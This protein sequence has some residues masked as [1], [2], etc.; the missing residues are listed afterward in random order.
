MPTQ[1]LALAC[2][3]A[4]PAGALTRFTK[5]LLGSWTLGCKVAQPM[6]CVPGYFEVINPHTVGSLTIPRA[7]VV[8]TL[9]NTY[10]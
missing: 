3:L 4:V 8:K 6:S 10:G 7:V 9:C 2:A 1:V 5:I